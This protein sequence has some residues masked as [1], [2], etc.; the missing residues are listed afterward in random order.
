MKIKTRRISSEKKYKI[1]KIEF[2]SW[3][4]RKDWKNALI[5]EK[6]KLKSRWRWEEYENEKAKNNMKIISLPHPFP[7]NTPPPTWRCTTLKAFRRWNISRESLNRE[8]EEKNL[9]SSA[10]NVM[11]MTMLGMISK[12][13][14]LEYMRNVNPLPRRAH[15]NEIWNI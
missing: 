7:R 9:I 3:E 2:Y 13:K 1:T 4:K 6:K 8:Q 10:I 5:F 15:I 11:I 12:W 14:E